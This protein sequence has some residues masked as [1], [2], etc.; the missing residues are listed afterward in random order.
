[1]ND[2]APIIGTVVGGITFLTALHFYL[3]WDMKRFD[4]E[5]EEYFRF[6]KSPKNK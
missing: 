3:K 1:M 5:T 6:L 4:K 2:W